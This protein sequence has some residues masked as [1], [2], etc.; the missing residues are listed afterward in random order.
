MA[1]D[2]RHTTLDAVHYL[3][4]LARGTLQHRT[5]LS[6][7]CH[8][9]H[10]NLEVFTGLLQEA[11]RNVKPHASNCYNKGFCVNSIYDAGWEF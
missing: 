7:Q 8:T 11:L 2:V 5:E 10:S 3:G 9:S 6:L 1:E 4:I